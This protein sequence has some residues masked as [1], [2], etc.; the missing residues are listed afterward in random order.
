MKER[1]RN[2]IWDF[3]VTKSELYDHFVFIQDHLSM[4]STLQWPDAFISKTKQP[5]KDLGLR[6]K[7]TGPFASNMQTA[8]DRF[9]I[10]PAA[11]AD[12]LRA[13]AHVPEKFEETEFKRLRR[14]IPEL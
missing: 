2:K 8:R 13:D 3:Y 7:P 11:G 6:T 5:A 12:L 14:K 10:V 1:R 4:V 9:F